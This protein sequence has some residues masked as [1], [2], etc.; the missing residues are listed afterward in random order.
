M[1]TEKEQRPSSAAAV[2]D[3]HN[4]LPHLIKKNKGKQGKPQPYQI[5]DSQILTRAVTKQ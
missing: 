2:R 4:S 3:T 1:P 5:S